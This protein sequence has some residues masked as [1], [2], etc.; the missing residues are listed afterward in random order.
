MEAALLAG[1]ALFYTYSNA[2]KKDNTTQ[3]DVLQYR[4]PKSYSQKTKNL[5]NLVTIQEDIK[6][7]GSQKFKI[8]RYPGDID[9]M[10]PISICCSLEDAI[11]SI[12]QS[13]KRIAIKIRDT[14]KIY[15]GD[16]KAGVDTRYSS[17]WNIGEID[18]YDNII[19]YDSQEV[20]SSI[21]DLHNNSLLS[22]TEFQELMKLVKH[23]NIS[24]GDWEKLFKMV[25]KKYVV[26]WTL[27][28]LIKG[29]KKLGP[30]FQQVTLDLGESLKDKTICKLDLW[31]KVNGNYTEI[32]NFFI[33]S[34]L[35]KEGKEHPVSPTL[36]GYNERII[37]DL[38]HYGEGSFYKPMKMAK[39][40]WALAVSIDDRKVLKKLYPL[41]ASDASM[42]YQ[43]IAEIETIE[44]ML[45][46]DDLQEKLLEDG[47][48]GD[49]IDQV[50]E[51][52]MRLSN[53]YNLVL[54]DDQLYGL[55]DDIISFKNNKIR[56]SKLKKFSNMLQAAVN[57][58]TESYLE[59]VGLEDPG[60]YDHLLE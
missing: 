32:T 22:N 36:D 51:F 23:E 1:T 9:L 54:D 56:V 8:A 41:F 35:D 28:E 3:F 34:Y 19:G 5:I 48:Y 30:K 31:A 50:D 2:N 58:Y 7:V 33:I 52:K 14:P 40:L 46:R 29:R 16:F 18:A 39:R 57:K 55:V 38:K 47:A 10:E 21:I 17:L 6:P 44:M 4:D 15:L 45:E 53:I 13:I 20:R 27:E 60:Y 26:R 25:K 12:K 59:E 42:L 24:R 11:K 37:K 49:L 43:I